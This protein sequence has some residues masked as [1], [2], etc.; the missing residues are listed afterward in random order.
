[1]PAKNLPTIEEVEAELEK[2]VGTKPAEV[3]EA[4]TR[5]TRKKK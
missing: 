5:T 3:A 4:Q 2:P 1:L